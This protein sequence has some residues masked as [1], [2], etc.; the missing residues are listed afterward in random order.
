MRNKIR[1]HEGNIERQEEGNKERS[2]KKDSNEDKT[3]IQTRTAKR[4][5]GGR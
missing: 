1:E 5:T 2:Q 3:Q 4:K